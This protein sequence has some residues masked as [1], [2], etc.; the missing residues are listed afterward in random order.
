MSD[1]PVIVTTDGPVTRVRLNKPPVNALDIELT[2]AIADAVLD[3]QHSDAEVV[4]FSGGDRT[5][6]AG[7]DIK[8][9]QQ[10]QTNGDRKS[11]RQYFRLIQGTYND[12]E[13]LPMPTIA[14]ITGPTLGGGLELALACDM[15]VAASNAKIGLPETGLG[16]LAGAGGVTRLP[17]LIGRGRALEL[18]YTTGTLTPEE[19]QRLGLINRLAEPDQLDAAVDQLVSETLRSSNV[20]LRLVKRAVIA[21]MDS[22]RTES[23][24]L[25]NKGIEELALHPDTIQRLTAF[26]EK[27]SKK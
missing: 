8:W 16:L 21:A 7:G 12:I 9:M 13:R 19:G 18:M 20:A 4:V 10:C 22:G 25:E 24:V 2:Q 1:Q 15:R 26:V 23:L 17:E 27:S 5:L 6:A 14:V 3:I 11:L